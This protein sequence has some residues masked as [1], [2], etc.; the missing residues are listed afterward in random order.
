M[1]VIMMKI[2]AIKIS[3]LLV[4]QTSSTLQTQAKTKQRLE[5]QMA[6]AERN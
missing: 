4:V 6:P 1:A 3:G 2:A 5:G